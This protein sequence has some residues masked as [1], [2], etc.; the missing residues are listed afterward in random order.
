MKTYQLHYH[1]IVNGSRQEVCHFH[2]DTRNL[3]LITPP[4]ISVMIMS[5]DVPMREE[6][7]V[8]LEIKR[9]GI[10][11]Y[12]KMKM[13]QLKCPEVVSD[14]MVQGPFPLFHHQRTFKHINNTTTEME[15]TITLAL[16][17]PILGK[18][19]FPWIKRDMDKLFAYRH[20]ATKRHFETKKAPNA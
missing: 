17:F 9:F 10:P 14:N 3:P 6:S 18:W 20:E 19:L 16:P 5:M 4:W 1:C 15:E 2:T 12:W 8:E 11:M 7:H 13:S